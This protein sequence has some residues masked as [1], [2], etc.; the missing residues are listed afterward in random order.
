MR[1]MKYC[2][3]VSIVASMLAGCGTNRPRYQ[4]PTGDQSSLAILKMSQK[5]LGIHN[6]DGAD[7][8][9][10]SQYMFSGDGFPETYFVTPGKH[11]VLAISG[12]LENQM[13]LWILAEPGKEYLLRMESGYGAFRMWFE[14]A[15]NGRSVGG[16]VGSDD[17]PKGSVKK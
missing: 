13:A 11:T 2:I 5:Y 10:F 8:I 6:I 3:W 4:Q 9:S 7:A 14:D 12:G 1:Q 17:E 16:L 15:S